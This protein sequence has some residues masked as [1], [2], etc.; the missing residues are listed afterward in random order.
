VLGQWIRRYGE[1][2]REIIRRHGRYHAGLEPPT[3]EP[4][5]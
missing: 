5:D 2:A 4:T 1:P 3:G